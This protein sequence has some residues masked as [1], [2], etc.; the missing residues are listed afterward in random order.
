MSKRLMEIEREAC[1]YI[2]L[3]ECRRP[4]P[5]RPRV[6]CMMYLK[7]TVWCGWSNASSRKDRLQHVLTMNIQFPRQQLIS[8]SILNVRRD[9]SALTWPSSSSFQRLAF[10]DC[11]CTANNLPFHF[12]IERIWIMLSFFTL[13]IKGRKRRKEPK[14]PR[15]SRPDLSWFDVASV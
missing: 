2:V 1:I 15:F 9:V 12:P 5:S 4:G 11:P 10:L 13:I 3:K 7:H 14:Y 8:K 6:N